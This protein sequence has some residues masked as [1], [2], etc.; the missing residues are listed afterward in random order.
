MQAVVCL[1]PSTSAGVAVGPVPAAWC[2]VRRVICLALLCIPAHSDVPLCCR[3]FVVSVNSVQGGV[4]L[5]VVPV[6]PAALCVL[7]PCLFVRSDA[8]LGSE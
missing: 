2:C 6:S 4:W 8:Y 7:P 5:Q 3:H 1:H